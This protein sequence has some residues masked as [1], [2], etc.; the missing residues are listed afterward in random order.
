A[1]FDLEEE[2]RLVENLLYDNSSPRLPKELNLEIA[3]MIL[4]SLSP[5]PIPVEDSD[6]QMEEIDLFFAT[7]DLMPSSIEN[8]DYDSEGVVIDINKRIKSKQNR[9]KSSTKRKAWKSQKS[10]KVN[11]KST[12]TK[13]KPPRI[14]SQ[15]K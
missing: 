6:S 10:I 2:I 5:F 7:D 11:K 15:K 14:S 3:D 1:D 12:P 4:E 13:S 8:D 9:T